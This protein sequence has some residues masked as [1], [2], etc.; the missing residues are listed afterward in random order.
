[1]PLISQREKDS[2]HNVALTFH[3]QSSENSIQHCHLPSTRVRLLINNIGNAKTTEHPQARPSSMRIRISGEADH[4]VG[5][6]FEFMIAR[7][8]RS[9]SGLIRHPATDTVLYKTGVWKTETNMTNIGKGAQLVMTEARVV[10]LLRDI[11]S[12]LTQ[13][14]ESLKSRQKPEITQVVS[15]L[16]ENT[17]RNELTVAAEAERTSDGVETVQAERN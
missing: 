17:K 14:N 5:G 4:S 6:G 3:I 7:S 9:Q 11:H 1:M 2:A 12:N 16:I 8:Y 10:L 15:G 13:G